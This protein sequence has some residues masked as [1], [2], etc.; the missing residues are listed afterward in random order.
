M[1]RPEVVRLC[2]DQR[3]QRTLRDTV[4]SGALN[5]PTYLDGNVGCFEGIKQLLRTDPAVPVIAGRGDLENS[6]VP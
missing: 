6:I 4:L 1:I 5:M 2:T 3:L